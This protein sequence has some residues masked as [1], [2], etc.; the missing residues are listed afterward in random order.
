MPG[1]VCVERHTNT[2][3]RARILHGTSYTL[4]MILFYQICVTK[5]MAESPWEAFPELKFQSFFVKNCRWI[6]VFS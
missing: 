1:A 3:D 6:A 5:S 2:P 4:G